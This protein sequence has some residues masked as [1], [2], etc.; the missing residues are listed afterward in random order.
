MKILKTKF[1]NNKYFLLG[2][3]TIALL[4]N[5]YVSPPSILVYEIGKLKAFLAKPGKVAGLY[6]IKLNIPFHRQEKTLSCEIASLKMVLNYAGVEVSESELISKL[7]FDPN[8]RTRKQWGDPYTGFVG[9]IDGKMGITGYGVYWDPI[10]EVANNYLRSE[11]ISN[12]TAEDIAGHILENR[13]VVL[14]GYFGRGKKITW[15]TPEGKEI[16]AINGEHA[17]VVTGFVGEKNQPLG[18]YLMDPIY[19][20]LYWKT[21]ELLKNSAPFNN[22]GVVVYPNSF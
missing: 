13:P 3:L 4:L 1:K 5:L 10:S 8:P 16:V 20:E 21:E 18:F 22:S 6:M 12:L 19:G 9:D 2:A 7:R 15:Q 11:A 17:R 14:W